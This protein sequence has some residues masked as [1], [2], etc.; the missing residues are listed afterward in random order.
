MVHQ[1]KKVVHQVRKRIQIIFA[2][3]RNLY[4]YTPAIKYPLYTE[5]MGAACV[6]GVSQVDKHGGLP[7]AAAECS[8]DHDEVGAVHVECSVD[9]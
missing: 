2:F 9:P 7:A 5:R 8:D 4:R 3:K 1:V 6:A